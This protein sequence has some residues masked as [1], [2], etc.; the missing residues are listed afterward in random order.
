[1]E[2]QRVAG[3]VAGIPETAR[4]LLK[5]AHGDVPEKIAEAWEAMRATRAA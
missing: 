5:V 2:A 4:V 1:M 3:I